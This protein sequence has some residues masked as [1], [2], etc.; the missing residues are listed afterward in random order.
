MEL[1]GLRRAIDSID[2]KILNLLN[3]RAKVT[4]KIGKI[5][6]KS[7]QSIYVPNR[8]SEVYARLA[9]NNKGPLSNAALQAIYREV[10]S[11]AL[12]LEKPLTIAYLGPVYTFTH[13]ASMK[14]FGSS[15]DYSS[16]NTITSVFDE[17]DK[18]RADYGVVPIENSVEG[19][20]NHT[21][22]MFIDSD[23]KI[24]S[25][26]YLEIS[27]SLLSK[28]SDR[29]KIKK[30]YSK[31]QVFGQCRLWLEEHLPNVTLVD[32]SS[33]ARAAEI[34]SKEKNAACIAS[35]LA[36]GKYGL[37]VLNRSIED[38]AH[39][40]TRFLVIGRTEARQ[41]KKDKTSIMFSLKDR[42]GALHD[43]LMPFKHNGI[44]LTKIESRPSKVNAWKYYFFVDMEGHH[45]DKKVAKALSILKKS[46]TYLKILGSYP[47]ADV[48]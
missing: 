39:N 11:S 36:A 12:N 8:E 43:I 4:L 10:M 14:K 31:D 1:K 24:C 5:K 44:N 35:E 15:V 40:V 30:I 9:N 17:V 47:A 22:D 18:G 23:L 13:L 32:V 29:K 41:T 38:N 45:A 16:C 48:I 3:E 2:S 26:I 33:T 34:A 6:S 46:T 37:K 25:E 19:A 21:L 42:V 27:H 20:V 7:N 28:E